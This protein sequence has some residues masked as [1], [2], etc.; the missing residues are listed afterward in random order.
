[1]SDSERVKKLESE[2]ES[3]TAELASFS[4]AVSHDLRAPLRAIAGFT[5]ALEEDYCAE[6][7][8]QGRD[9]IRRV[10]EGVRQMEQYMEGLLEL[11][12]VS[13][14]PFRAED[15]DLSRVAAR[16][17]A[18]LVANE[19]ARKV[20]FSVAP[21]LHVHGDAALLKIAFEHLLHNAWKFTSKHP[22]ARIEVGRDRDDTIFIRDDGAGFDPAFAGRMFAPFQRAHSATLFEG[23]GIGLAIVQRIVHRHGWKVRAWG[24]LDKGATVYIDFG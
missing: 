1:M 8:E 17:A 22:T 18:D 12:R 14:L 7:D 13:R 3:I 10:R 6:L 2:L 21:G 9:Y 11:S 5:E 23:A 19:P 20:E 4:Y 15:V 16:I 24:Q